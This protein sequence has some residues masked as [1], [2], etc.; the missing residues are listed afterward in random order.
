MNQARAPL[1]LSILVA[2]LLVL[3]WPGPLARLGLCALG[4]ACLVLLGFIMARHQT[5]R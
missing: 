3:L 2:A 1:G 5:P 4:L